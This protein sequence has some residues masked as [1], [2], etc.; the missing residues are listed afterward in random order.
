MKRVLNRKEENAI[1]DNLK[2][3]IFSLAE[4]N[5]F[6]SLGLCGKGLERSCSNSNSCVA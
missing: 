1:N 3:L 4:L 2:D 6:Y 5:S